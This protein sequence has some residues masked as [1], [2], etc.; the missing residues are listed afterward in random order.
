M[1]T[2]LTNW[3]F[4]EVV[5]HILQIFTPTIFFQKKFFLYVKMFKILIL[6][7]LCIL[8]QVNGHGYLAKPHSRNIVDY[9]NNNNYCPHCSNSPS[10]LCC[11]EKYNP[12]YS[13]DSIQQIYTSGQ[14]V[15]FV[16]DITSN[17]QGHVEF[18]L[19]NTEHLANK[20][21]ITKEC[22]NTQL[23]RDMD[24]D[25]SFFGIDKEYPG[26]FFIEPDYLNDNTKNTYVNFGKQMTATY[27]LP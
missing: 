19:C 15:E 23:L 1:Y 12:F 4:L 2:N 25:T 20:N 14:K 9:F 26:R 27:K 22:L 3:L 17:H 6:K 21:I 7:L 5:Y 13:L 24:N 16:I 11:D 18:F 8:Q 10:N